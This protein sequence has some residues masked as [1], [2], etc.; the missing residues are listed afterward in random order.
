MQRPCA[1]CKENGH[2]IR[3]CSLLLEKN[4]RRE[5]VQP[6]PVSVQQPSRKPIIAPKNM[7]TNLYDSSDDEVEEEVAIV[8]EPENA[9]PVY[10]PFVIS[11]Y[12]EKY[13]GRSWVDIEYDSDLNN[14]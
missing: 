8:S 9:D 13:I 10:K 7:Y 2:H 12:L 6:V 11:A 1:Y 4:R 14:E 5:K 3:V